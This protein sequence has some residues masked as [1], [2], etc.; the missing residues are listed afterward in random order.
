MSAGSVPMSKIDIDFIRAQGTSSRG[1]IWFQPVRQPIGTSM[2]SDAAVPADVISGR[3]SIDLVRLP[4]GT[5][6]V[7][8]QIDDRPDRTYYFALP[9]GSPEVV[10]YESIVPVVEVPAVHQYV[11]KIN[12]ISPNPTTGNIELEALEGPQGPEGPE[13]PAGPKGDKGDDGTDG[14]N[15]T[16]GI[17]G[18]N[19]TDGAPG[20]DGILKAFGTTGMITGTFGPAG[21][22]GDWDYCP[23][24]YR[25]KCIAAVGD[26]ILWTPGFLHKFDQEAV[27]DLAAFVDGAPVR[28]RSS[29]TSVPLSSGY[30]GLYMHAT[31]G[32]LRPVW[33]TVSADDISTE[34]EVTLALAFRNNGSGNMMGHASI[35]GD[36]SLANAGPGGVL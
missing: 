7:V 28:F 34:G 12:G 32:G 29:G 23:V 26:R 31:F 14:V 20:R 36:I 9:V 25:P 11:S 17:N 16:N 10:Q 30:G 18:T 6:R 24:P 19:G 21:D 8:E 33:W 5:Y 22:T 1:R 35:A 15:G 27:C 4:V 2:L 3:G 13:G